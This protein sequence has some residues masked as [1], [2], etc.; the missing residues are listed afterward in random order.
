MAQNNLSVIGAGGFKSLV[1]IG[2]L[3]QWIEQRVNDRFS[4]GGD[5]A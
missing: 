3:D 5:I 1:S 2:D 4:G